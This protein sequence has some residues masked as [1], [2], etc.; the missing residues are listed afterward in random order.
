MYE[1]GKPY[2]YRL[3]IQLNKRMMKDIEKL[4]ASNAPEEQ[5]DEILSKYSIARAAIAYE[6]GED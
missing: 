4:A 6:Y 2:W 5:Q 3:I 1:T